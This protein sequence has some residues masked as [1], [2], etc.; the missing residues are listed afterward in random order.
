MLTLPEED[1]PHRSESQCREMASSCSPGSLLGGS[2]LDPGNDFCGGGRWAARYPCEIPHIK[3]ELPECEISEPPVNIT[4]ASE[5]SPDVLQWRPHGCKMQRVDRGSFAKHLVNATVCFFGDSQM[6]HIHGNV[7]EIMDGVPLNMTGAVG[8]ATDK[9]ISHSNRWLYSVDRSAEWEIGQENFTGCS[10]VVYNIGQW[11]L[12]WPAG[13]RPMPAHEYSSRVKRIVR[14]LAVAREEGKSVFWVTTNSH[15]MDPKDGFKSIFIEGRDWR[16]DPLLLT[17]NKIANALAADLNIPIIDTYTL[18]S[19]MNE[20]SYDGAHYRGY[21]G[22]WSA[23][24]VLDAIS[25][26]PEN[27][28]VNLSLTLSNPNGP[29]MHDYTWHLVVANMF[30]IVAACAYFLVQSSKQPAVGQS[31]SSLG[32]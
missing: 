27:P 3:E 7:V 30:F 29:G 17:Y 15:P 22:Y 8:G 1:A 28:T 20:Y 21:V 13:D 19:I 10:T 16:T 18:T 5:Y 4:F 6:R 9:S 2:S 23:V 12:G 14:Q 24:V 32:V 26:R 31:N 11:A 25:R